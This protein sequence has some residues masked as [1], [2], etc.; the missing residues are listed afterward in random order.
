MLLSELHSDWRYPRTAQ[1]I[2]AAVLNA[3]A[4]FRTI[5][6]TTVGHSL[7]APAEVL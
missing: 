7:G 6:V 2:L 3:T 5:K 4:V 1:S